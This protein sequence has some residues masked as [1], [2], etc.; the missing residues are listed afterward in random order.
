MDGVATAG[1]GAGAL[2]QFTLLMGYNSEGQ[3]SL[4]QG[5]FSHAEFMPGGF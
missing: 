2:D 4:P 3:I 1:L 5:D